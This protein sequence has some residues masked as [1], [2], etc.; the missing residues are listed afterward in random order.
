VAI[1]DSGALAS[2]TA[3]FGEYLDRLPGRLVA[4]LLCEVRPV[5]DVEAR[6][7]A[8]QYERQFVTTMAIQPVNQGAAALLLG[9]Y[10]L[11]GG[12]ACALAFGVHTRVEI[13]DS[14]AQ[15]S[16]VRSDWMIQEAAS[17]VESV[18]DGCTEFCRPFQSTRL[19]DML[20]AYG[21]PGEPRW[22]VGVESQH[23]RSGRSS[24]EA[25]EPFEQR[26]L[27]WQW[28]V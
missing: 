1:D 8:G 27:P 28:R 20:A 4:Q 9:R 18:V 15:V 19:T 17:M 6:R 11:D 3:E 22:S 7:L 23:G 10:V 5:T 16:D 14:Y 24:D 13:P 26:W 2:Q 21:P 25:L 12:H